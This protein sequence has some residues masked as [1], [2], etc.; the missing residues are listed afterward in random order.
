MSEEWDNMPIY[1]KGYV[2]NC[3]YYQGTILINGT[4]IK[5]NIQSILQY[6]TQHLASYRAGL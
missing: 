2:M 5:Y 6:S 1:K 3:G 4:M